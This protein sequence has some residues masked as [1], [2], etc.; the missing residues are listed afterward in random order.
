M[1]RVHLKT[2]WLGIL[3]CALAAPA[4]PYSLTGIYDFRSL[5]TVDATL[6]QTQ[7]D[8]PALVYEFEGLTF[9]Q[10]GSLWAAVAADPSAASREFWKLDLASRTAPVRI[11]DPVQYH[12]QNFLGISNPVALAS[13]GNQLIVGENGHG[14]GN[15]VWAFTPGSANT[16]DWDF[17]KA[18]GACNEVEGLAHSGGKLYM[19][20]Q[21]DKKI[22][23]ITDNQGTVARTFTFQ[24]QVLG[25][26]ETGDGRLLVGA[27]PSRQ[28]LI[29]DPSGIRPTESIS[30]E[31]LF[32][33]T[34]S[35]Y[36]R[37]TGQEYGVQV[38][39]GESVR[40]LPDPDALAFKDGKIYM[41]F[42]GDLRIYEISP[43][44]VPEPETWALML[45]GLALVALAARRRQP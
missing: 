23:E 36:Y 31:S 22:L 11:P 40:T 45:A 4:H 34:N 20:C 17:F 39:P 32:G 1:T 24:D 15:L 37:L 7:R 12:P 9:T 8:Y 5:V 35:D 14:Y 28:V 30:L 13:D 25:L 38:V 10:D 33:G 42:D 19:G 3:L 21:N 44:P 6:T 41:A 2:R 43:T 16:Y 27:Y 29:F 26:E 18:S